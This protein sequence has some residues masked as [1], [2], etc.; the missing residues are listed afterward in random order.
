[1]A[2]PP[3]AC[4]LAGGGY[5]QRCPAGWLLASATPTLVGER[6]RQQP[7]SQC[8]PRAGRRGHEEPALEDAAAFDQQLHVSARWE[9]LAVRRPAPLPE[10]HRT[11]AMQPGRPAEPGHAV[12]EEA[13][14]QESSST[15]WALTRSISA[16]AEPPAATARAALL[17]PFR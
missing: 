11:V 1:M 9:V 13:R 8:G 14:P 17:M 4:C 10:G 3:A 6:D 16:G 5:G 2:F 15:S 12:L 7:P